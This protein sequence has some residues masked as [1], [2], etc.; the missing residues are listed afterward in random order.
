MPLCG[1]P[2][3]RRFA[4][5]SGLR[6]FVGVTRR[7]PGYARFGIVGARGFPM[8]DSELADTGWSERGRC[9]G[10]VGYRRDNTPGGTFFFTVALRDRHAALL[11]D[12]YPLLRGALRTV[13]DARPF[14]IA[15][16]V[17]LP[18]HLH[19]VWTLPDAD[20]D[21]PGRW[22]AIKAAFVRAL[23]RNG[24]RVRRNRRG[25][26]DVWQRRYWEHRIRDER[27]LRAHIDYIHFNPVKHGHAACA[28]DWPY[29]TIHEHIRRGWLPTDWGTTTPAA[30]A[31]IRPRRASPDP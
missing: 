26:A 15:A 1:I 21:Y 23:T 7:H 17:V 5:S 13:R 9:W 27:D 11:V 4:P 18:D 10:M 22:R 31:R 6:A 28:V 30:P 16:L 20:A 25:E 24:V 19:A 29:S 12:H 3:F 8:R 2:G 14:A